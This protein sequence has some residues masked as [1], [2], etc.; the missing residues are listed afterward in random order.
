MRTLLCLLALFGA[1]GVSAQGAEHLVGR[2]Y[3]GLPGGWAETA[4]GLMSARDGHDYTVSEHS[5]LDGTD[6]LFVYDRI[7]R[8][9]DDR[10]PV[11]TVVAALV[12]DDLRAGETATVFGCTLD[13]G[14]HEER[15]VAVVGEATLVEAEYVYRFGTVRRA[16]RLDRDA[17]RFVPLDPSRVECPDVEPVD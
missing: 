12:V 4:G 7:D 16:W 8:M 2:P 5:R 15:V 3:A 10:Y 17:E 11:A 1:T 14:R 6:L 13:G 9:Q